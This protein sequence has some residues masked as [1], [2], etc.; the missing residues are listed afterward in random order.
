MPKGMLG[1]RRLRRETKA[2]KRRNG[3]RCIGEV[4]HGVGD[5]GDGTTHEAERKFDGAEEEIDCYADAAAQIPVGKAHLGQCGLV[6]VLDETAEKNFV[7]AVLCLHGACIESTATPLSMT[8]I[9]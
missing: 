5:D 3:R 2:Q 8:C 6:M 9:P 7:H 1:V 4:V